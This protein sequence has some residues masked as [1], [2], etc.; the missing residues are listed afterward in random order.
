MKRLLT[1]FLLFAWLLPSP[2][3][4]AAGHFTVASCSDAST[5]STQDTCFQLQDRKWYV[6][7]GTNWIDCP[8]GACALATK[9]FCDPQYTTS[10][11]ITHADATDGLI[12]AGVAGKKITPCGGYIIAA[13]AVSAKFIRSSGGTCAGTDA[14]F[15]E[16][17]PLTAQVGH[18]IPAG[19]KTALGDSFCINLSAAIAVTGE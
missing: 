16:A 11:G 19:G 4:A 9:S 18:L 10:V 6:F 1:L 3:Q 13:G 15:T 7:D 12:V 2:V 8:N 5:P 14:N 17:V